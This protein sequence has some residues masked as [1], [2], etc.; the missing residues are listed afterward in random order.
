[1]KFITNFIKKFLPKEMPKPVG[2]WKIEN[3][4]VKTNNKVDL[5][6]EDHCGPCGQYALEKI[7]LK[8]SNVKVME[9]LLTS[10]ELAKRRREY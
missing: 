9:P 8:N 4:N 5:S 2:R 1:M 6:N 7:E 3:C 10:E